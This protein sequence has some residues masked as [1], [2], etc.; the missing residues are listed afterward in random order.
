LFNFYTG[1]YLLAGLVYPWLYTKGTVRALIAA[2]AD[3]NTTGDS[4]ETALSLANEEGNTDIINLLKN[5]GAGL[6]K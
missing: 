5:A 3:V 1:K 6:K 4:S 2:G